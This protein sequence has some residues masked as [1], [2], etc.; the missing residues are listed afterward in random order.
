MKK[1]NIFYC[2]SPLD[3]KNIIFSNYY[4]TKEFLINVWNHEF[5]EFYDKEY[6]RTEILINKKLIYFPDLKHNL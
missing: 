3:K 2:A 1:K 6:F 4:Q 5:I